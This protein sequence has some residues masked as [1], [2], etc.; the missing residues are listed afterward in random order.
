MSRTRRSGR[1]RAP[2]WLSGLMVVAIAGCGGESTGEPQLEADE[3]NLA[4]THQALEA[5]VC[6]TVRRGVL[7]NVHDTFLSGDYPTWATGAESSLWSGLSGGGSENRILLSFDLSFLPSYANVVSATLM[8]RTSWNEA[9]S[10][11]RL[12]QVV[13]PWSE[14]T[15][16][17]Q[18]F[19]VSGYD[20]ATI[21]TFD[22]EGYDFE[23]V[24]ITPL[25][26]DWVKGVHPNYGVLI[27]EDAVATH[28]FWS[29]EASLANRPG[30]AVC[31]RN[32][33]KP[34]KGGALSA[35][36]V[37]S[38]SEGFHFIGTLGEGP[39]ANRV[40]TSENHRFIGGLVG[41]TQE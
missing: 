35:G 33:P 31:Y 19:G 8:I 3:E 11:A 6:V 18:N 37:T 20:P 24:S 10:T 26:H 4:D 23:S 7:G 29:S 30:L 41:A 32:G 21:G 38:D 34:H 14:A 13:Q 22:P 36:A 5:P 40:S 9:H 16:T 27:E 25:V 39:G 1:G 17:L 28:L 12:H 15:A 2:G